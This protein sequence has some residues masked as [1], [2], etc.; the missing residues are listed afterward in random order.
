MIANSQAR[1]GVFRGRV[2][3]RAPTIGDVALAVVLVQRHAEDRG[4]AAARAGEQLLRA[5]DRE[6]EHARDLAHA[7]SFRV[8]QPEHLRVALRQPRQHLAR[9][10]T[11][12]E[13]RLEAVR[14]RL[15]L[16][17]AFPAPPRTAGVAD[18]GDQ[19]RAR[20][21]DAALR[22]EKADEDVVHEV[23]GIGLRD[24][25]LLRR[26]A[27]QER[28]DPRVPLFRLSIVHS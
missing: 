20:L 14:L 17:A 15:R 7:P 2:S 12:H 11:H 24:A 13:R 21:R 28:R 23:L 16:R 6:A 19:P 3:A 25:E 4:G 9:G 8:L 22:P 10:E 18:R 27:V 5:A 1:I 26:H